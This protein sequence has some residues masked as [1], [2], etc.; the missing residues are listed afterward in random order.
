MTIYLDTPRWPLHGTVWGHVISDASLEELHAFAEQAG[1]P[2]RGFDLDHY[3]YPVRTRDK[4]IHLGAVEVG[5]RQL[6]R[7]L[8]DSGLRVPGRDR[9]TPRPD[10]LEGPVGDPAEGG[11]E[12]R[13]LRETVVG[14]DGHSRPLPPVATAFRF[15]QDDSRTSRIQAI[16]LEGDR[17]AR[18]VLAGLD[19]HARALGGECF[20]GMVTEWPTEVPDPD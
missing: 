7:I 15:S 2:R 6:A 10:V 19:A 14:P 8:R 1:L 9:G 11:L 20:V 5:N 18:V 16:D 3:D 13:R 17:R 4:L 12:A